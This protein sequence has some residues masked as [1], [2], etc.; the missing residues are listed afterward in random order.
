MFEQIA[1]HGCCR[2]GDNDQ[3][4]NETLRRLAVFVP[5]LPSPSSLLFPPLWRHQDCCV[6]DCRTCTSVAAAADTL[7]EHESM[8]NRLQEQVGNYS[9]TPPP[10]PT[11]VVYLKV[12]SIRCFDNLRKY[13]HPT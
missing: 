13:L 1:N 8:S 2:K 11:H 7:A 5:P 9:G 4:L 3:G 12:H 6:L 10:F